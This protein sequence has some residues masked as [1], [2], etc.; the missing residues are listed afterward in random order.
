[1]IYFPVRCGTSDMLK[2]NLHPRT[3]HLERYSKGVLSFQRYKYWEDIG[4]KINSAKRIVCNFLSL[5]SY[6]QMR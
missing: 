2:V 1:M 4:D 3:V 5:I 6:I